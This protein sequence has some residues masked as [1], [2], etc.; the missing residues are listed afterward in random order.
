MLSRGAQ[1]LLDLIRWY[2]SKFRRV[3]PFQ[4]KLAGHLGVTSRQVRR[5]VRELVDAF[6]LRVQ[7]CGRNAAEYELAP[8]SLT[9]NVRS[10]S[11]Q[12]PV[13]PHRPFINTYASH[14]ASE[15]RKPPQ[16]EDI[17]TRLMR[18]YAAEEASGSAA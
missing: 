6:L 7:K 14:G 10:K 8:E 9:G 13:E 5:Y 1:R 12:C 2:R 16:R 11:A 3:F 15:Q 18:R 4:L 17:F